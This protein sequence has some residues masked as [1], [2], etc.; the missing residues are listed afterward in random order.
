MRVL[1][2]T[3]PARGSGAVHMRVC[4]L[5][6]SGLAALPEV[7]CLGLTQVRKATTKG[8]CQLDEWYYVQ[9]LPKQSWYP[10]LNERA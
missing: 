7:A 10:E 1:T 4:F 5:M 9:R 8:E 3:T 2:C 6:Q